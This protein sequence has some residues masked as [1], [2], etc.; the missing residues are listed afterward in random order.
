MR[1]ADARVRV[2]VVLVLAA[3]ATAVL[4]V[5]GWPVSLYRD[6]D[7]ASF[8]VMGRMLLDGKD[9]Y[10]FS[11][12]LAAHRAIESK[13]LTI[14][15]AGTPTF[16]PLTTALLCAPFALFPLALAAPMWLVTQAVLAVSALVALG[17]RLFPRALP[18][19]LLVLGIGVACQPAWLLAA[20]GNMGGFLVAIVASSTALL[21][22]GRA[23]AAGAVAGLLVVKPHLLVFALVALLFTLPRA[24]AVRFFG[25]AAAVGGALTLVT[26]ILNPRWIGE[27]LAEI[28]PIATYASRQATVFGLLGPDLAAVEWGI[29]AASLVAFVVWARRARPTLA[30]LVAAAIPL[31]L[32]CA[33]YGWSYDQLLLLV[34]AA[35]VV[36]LVAE[37]RETV[38]AGVLFALALVLVPL[39]WLL[40]VLAFRRGD[41]SLTA[42]VP[43][44]VLGVLALA[45]RVRS[46][47]TG[48]PPA[49]A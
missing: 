26:L 17:Q 35:V 12:Y 14:V 28:G 20:G 33:R 6:N 16:Y 10:D 22:S 44:A 9:Q 7:F 39:P 4:Y 11:A 27:L 41:E 25:A 45:L 43:L 13:A 40:F 1:A 29:V 46:T 32:F 24:T 3:G 30:V 23:V 8:W 34:T 38:R 19:N 31:S 48:A 2:A 5:M 18:R 49:G 36:G 42:V 15:V 21:L 37:S 47:S